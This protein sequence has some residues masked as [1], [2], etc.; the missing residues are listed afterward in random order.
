M[1]SLSM[2]CMVSFLFIVDLCFFYASKIFYVYVVLMFILYMQLKVFI[3]V[4]AN[5]H[6][7]MCDLNVH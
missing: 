2:G 7:F 6:Y 5:V 1:G 3:I 4:Y